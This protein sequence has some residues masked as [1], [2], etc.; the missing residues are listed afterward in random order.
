MLF[1][2][3]VLITIHCVQINHVLWFQIMKCGW[4]SESWCESL[5]LQRYMSLTKKCECFSRET[6]SALLAFCAGNSPVPVNS[7]HKGQWRR[8][9]MFSLKYYVIVM[10]GGK[11]NE[12]H[13]MERV[14]GIYI[15]RRSMCFL[16]TA[17]VMFQT[18]VKMNEIKITH[19]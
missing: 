10:Y 2:H 16:R 11:Y 18:R 3:I 9:L 5:S 13:N 4:R 17:Y 7:P 15:E 1:N 6:F 19:S 8:A 12:M 14:W